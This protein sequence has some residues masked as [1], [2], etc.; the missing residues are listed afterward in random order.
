LRVDVILVGDDEVAGVVGPDD[1]DDD[2]DGDDVDGTDNFR[3]VTEVV[4]EIG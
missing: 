3:G 1:E 2:S 4:E